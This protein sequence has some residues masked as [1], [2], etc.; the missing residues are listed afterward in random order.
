MANWYQRLRTENAVVL[1]LTSIPNTTVKRAADPHLGY[2]YAVYFDDIS[3]EKPALAI[4]VKGVEARPSDAHPFR[5]KLSQN[6][7]S[8]IDGADVPVMLLVVHIP[9]SEVFLTWLKEPGADG[10]RIANGCDGGF[11]LTKASD[12]SLRTYAGAAKD[13]ATARVA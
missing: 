5:A 2:D 3:E 4:E 12:A 13:Y 10:L 11:H 9:E 6:A 8:F 7:R 1:A